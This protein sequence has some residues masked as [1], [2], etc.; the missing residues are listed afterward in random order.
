[1]SLRR[2]FKAEAERLADG[3]RAEMGLRSA[4]PAF[5][6]AV[7]AHLGIEVR[8]GDELVG[9]ER[10]IELE[11]IQP[12]AFFACTFRPTPERT[13]VVLSPLSVETRQ[14]SDLA[15]E[16]AHIILEHDLSR[17]ERVGNLTF[18]VCD[19]DQEEEAAWLSG[20]LLLPRPLLISQLKS[21]VGALDIAARLG[22]SEH[23][24]TYR[25]N[26]TGVRRQL[27]IGA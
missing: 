6:R 21:G 14:N 11:Q 27:G 7:A 17:L 1:M 5:P 4:D 8:L 2:G 22:V 19:S 10:F 13:V 25:I 9:R 15:H 23:M 16:L 20:C 26:V 18:F 3:I 12:G 24:V